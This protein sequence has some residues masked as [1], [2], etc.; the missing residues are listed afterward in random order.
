MKEIID[1]RPVEEIIRDLK[2]KS[3][4]VI[5]WKTLEK[6][7]NPKLHAIVTDKTLRPDKVRKNG[8]IE[9][10]ARITYG[11]QR[12]AARRMTQMAFAIP[13]KR[14]YDTKKDKVKEEQA[15]AIEAVYKTARIDSINT[16]RMFAYFASCEIASMWFPVKREGNETYGFKSDY[17]LRCRSYSPMDSK[18]SRIECAGLYPVFDNSG[19]M[20]YM[21]FEYYRI[22]DNKKIQYFETF[23]KTEHFVWKNDGGWK[24]SDDPDD[25]FEVVIQKHPLSYLQRPLPIWEDT[26][27]NNQE[28]EF[29][30]S[31][32]SDI[33][34]KNSA[35]IVKLE[36]KLLNGEAPET[37][38]AREVYQM[39]NG[40]NVAYVTWE[41][42]IEA[43][44]YFI[45]TLKKNTEEELQLPS[46][47]LESM[48]SLGNIGYDARK[49]LLTDPHL[50]VGDESGD[51][52]EFL[53]RECNV[54]KAFLGEMNT[55]WKDSIKDLKVTHVITPFIQ[56]DEK[57]DIEKYSKAAGGSPSPHRE[58][59]LKGLDCVKPPNRLRRK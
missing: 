24:K 52:I 29:A 8:T 36:G 31:R 23:S 47:S 37:E 13:V 10:V 34:K 20:I 35:P 40:G 57:E 43:L 3:V 5:P 53:D 25:F 28:I 59:V 33:L 1:D 54:I 16:K 48:K 21:S 7:F 18:F 32:E 38:T 30:L 4:E 15:R 45:E 51:I 19:D 44:R 9:K 46:L 26:S 58:S 42:Q 11:G 22:E 49:T 2:K 55:K 41:Q 39:E 17:E 6:E 50:K 12:L 14:L 56:N 27:A